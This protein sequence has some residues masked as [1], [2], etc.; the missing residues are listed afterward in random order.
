[1]NY[2]LQTV[3]CRITLPTHLKMP[4]SQSLEPVNMYTMQRGIE[5]ASGTKVANQLNPKIGRWPGWAQCNHGHLSKWRQLVQKSPC[6]SDA[7]WEKTPPGIAGFEAGRGLQAKIH[8]CPLE[9]RKGEKMDAHLEVPEKNATLLHLDF[10]PAGPTS[11]LW[12]T[13]L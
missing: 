6:R 2:N 9:A 13:Q 8:R 12:P 4:T 3:A 1:M 7:L 10:S 11:N 5:V